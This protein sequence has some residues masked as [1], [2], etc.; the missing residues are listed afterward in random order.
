MDRDDE[1][2]VRT[3]WNTF[4]TGMC[5]VFVV[6][7]VSASPILV[8]DTLGFA[9]PLVSESE[10]KIA[11]TQ[12]QRGIY[13]YNGDGLPQSYENAAK[14]F[15]KAA[16]QGHILAQFN[17]GLMYDD[18]QGVPQSYTEAA[19]W[20]RKAAEQGDPNA[21]HNLG[22][23]YE[24]GQGVPQSY[25]EA[26]KW[27]RKAADQGCV[28]A[29]NNLG[30]LYVD[31]NGVEQSHVEAVKWF[32]KAADQGDATAQCNLG[33]HYIRGN[34][35]EQSNTE[36][37]RWFRKAAEQGYAN[38][39]FNLAQCYKQGRG[40]AQSDAEA[41]KWFLKAAEQGDVDAQVRLGLLY[42]CGEGVEQSYVEAAK[43][44]RKAADQGNTDAEEAL[45]ILKGKALQVVEKSG[46]EEAV[47]EEKNVDFTF[48]GIK[49]GS[50][51]RP[52]E[53]SN[54]G[55]PMF[56]GGL[57]RPFRE[58]REVRCFL[59]P[60]SKQCFQIRLIKVFDSY[61]EMRREQETIKQI[62]SIKYGKSP[63]LEK[64][65]DEENDIYYW[66]LE[67]YEIT[68][69]LDA[70]TDEKIWLDVLSD[71][72]EEKAEQELRAKTLEENASDL[73]AL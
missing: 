47:S 15:R 71:S 73:D 69:C 50:V 2:W 24:K 41:V 6:G 65:N 67:D 68:I 10:H 59:T 56:I 19:K 22:V 45:Q 70:P 40:V 54:E 31:G 53:V 57:R 49:L 51:M 3:R 39:Q 55:Y 42:S 43:W 25:I 14:W 72:L 37:F 4:R 26:A 27:Y 38:A 52:T 20:Y 32:R 46:E 63:D 44:Y 36:A 23:M 58:I 29:Q 60:K 48:C 7:I 8:A 18:G 21:Q 62:L 1:V 61:S 5:V 28:S 11:D 17:L 66:F 30:F 34:G 12:F 16:D 35:V 9:N 64:K 33:F 13:Y